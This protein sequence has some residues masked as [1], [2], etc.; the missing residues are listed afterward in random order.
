MKRMALC[1]LVACHGGAATTP[2]TNTPT[3]IDTAR[4]DR[5]V[6]PGD[7]FYAYANGGWL[8]SHEIPPDRA[9]VGIGSQVFDETQRRTAELIKTADGAP[10]GTEARKIGDLYASYMD[11]ATIEAKGIMPLAP[12]LAAFAAVTDEKSLARALGTTLRADVDVL[13]ATHLT[14]PNLF[15]M[16]IAQDLD[17]PTKYAAF[18]LQGGLEMPSR[19]Y[20]LDPS[21]RM[22]AIR[23]KY[24]AHVVALL[25]LAQINDADDKATRIIELERKIAE[26]H[27]TRVE[28]E[29]VPNSNNHWT[30]A[31][32]VQR[33]PGLDWA[34]FFEAAGL[35]KL[36]GIVAWHP[37]AIIK[38]AALVHSEPVATWRDYLTYH[39]VAA[40]AGRLTK[41]FVDENFAFYGTVLAGV[42]QQ[43]ER[44]KRAVDL[45][46]NTLGEPVGKIY[47]AKYFPPS[48]QRAQLW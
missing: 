6:I 38:L 34:V 20:Y 31:E 15:G 36:Q 46:S 48:E 47:V 21:P 32:L 13:N 19:D 4:I 16:W 23:D 33:A 41:S 26:A 30:R 2:S 25:K 7:D 39:A 29:D 8:K 45:T 11:E 44:W 17:D 43:R 40:A 12:A 28:T 3:K 42:E 9:V 1:V 18:M 24:K 5:S 22:V 27:A 14:T 37:A 10:A 35:A